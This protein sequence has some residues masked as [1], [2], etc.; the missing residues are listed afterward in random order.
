M[1]KSSG[2]ENP[3]RFLPI[4]R[5]FSASKQMTSAPRALALWLLFAT[6][7]ARYA[8]P[9]WALDR[10]PPLENNDLLLEPATPIFAPPESLADEPGFFERWQR[11]HQQRAA[12]DTTGIVTDRPSFTYSDTTVPVGWVQV[13]TGYV[14]V[15]NNSP[16]SPLMTTR[17]TAPELTL[18][19]GVL[20]R[21]EFRAAWAG[22]AFFQGGGSTDPWAG[23]LQLGFKFQVSQNRGWMPRSALLTSIYVPNGDGWTL[24]MPSN[25][26]SYT[27]DVAPLIDYIYS[28]SLTDRLSIGGSTGAIF[29]M[30]EQFTLTDFFQSAILRFQWTERLQLFGEGYAVFGSARQRWEFHDP[31]LI[32]PYYFYYDQ[33]NYT[34]AYLD[35]GVLWRPHPTFNSTGAPGWD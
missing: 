8:E 11:S 1:F 26:L 35:G 19:V 4:F 27:T 23:N 16:T 12:A 24:P 29:G 28:W 13:E 33:T 9:A 2:P 10:V 3:R 34:A 15:N 5:P 21:V 17:N 7:C 30:Q 31:F 18:R 22:L 25:V 20:P 32:G 14:Y 6:L